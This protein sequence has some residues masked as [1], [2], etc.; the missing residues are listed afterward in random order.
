MRVPRRTASCSGT[1]TVIVDPSIRFCMILW[2]P[3]WRAATNPFCSRIP[4]ISEPD[5]TRSLPN[6]YLNLRY[7]YFAAESP[8][9]FRRACVF[10]E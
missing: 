8:V 6:R 5:R 7:E 9:D 3:R 1:G 4:Q 10:E 2:L